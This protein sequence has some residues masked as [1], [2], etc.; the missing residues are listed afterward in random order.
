MEEI[1]NDVKTPIFSKSEL[2][3]VELLVRGYSEKEIADRLH[4]SKHTVNNH[5]R[6]IRE[7]NGLT[8]TQKLFY[9]T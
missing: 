4:L 2:K 9:Y 7:R 1:Y 3:V 5:M 8:K 6:N